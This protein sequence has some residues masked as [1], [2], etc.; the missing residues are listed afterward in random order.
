MERWLSSLRAL[1]AL[2][3]DLVSVLTNHIVL[4]GIYNSKGLDTL[5]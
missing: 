3:E 5:F 1:V 4:T 2:T